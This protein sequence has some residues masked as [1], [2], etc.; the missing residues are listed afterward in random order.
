MVAK[1]RARGAKSSI[2]T[3][4]CSLATQELVVAKLASS[5]LTVED[6]HSLG[7]YGLDGPATAQLF[8]SFDAL[9]SL[10]IPY[11][12]PADTSQP[13]S[14]APQW[15][16]FYRLR[17]LKEG[18][19]FGDKTKKKP[20]RYTQPGAT[21]VCA[22][23]PRLPEFSW[24]E[25]MRNPEVDIY[26]T[27][28][29]LKAAKAVKEGFPTIGLGGVYN[30]AS[31]KL[32]HLF[33]PE[34]EKINW[35]KRQ[36]FIIY[37]SDA[38]TNTMVCR[39]IN[40]L[41]EELRLRGALP[42]NVSLPSLLGV[43]QKTGLDDY[44]ISEGPEGLRSL[45]NSAYHLTFARPLWKLN[46]QFAFIQSTGLVVE[47]ETG[48]R[49][50][51]PKFNEVFSTSTYLSQKINDKGELVQELVPASKAWLTWPL[52][53]TLGIVTY[54]PGKPKIIEHADNY[55]RTGYNT[56]KGWGTEPRKGDVSMF[57][58]LVNHLFTG[59][60]SGAK[61]WF[62][63][64]C[65]YPFQYP[66]IK[67]FT[68]VIL[69]GIHHGTG[70][71]QVGY[72]LRRLYGEN[73]AEIKEGDLHGSFND[74]AANR[75][76]VLAD[77]ITGSAK[78]Q[79]ADLLK[80]LITQKSLRI[81]AKYLPEY[82][83]PDCVNYLFTSNSVDALFLEDHDRRY[84]V[85]EVTVKPLS[86]EFYM[87]F[88]VWLS[89]TEGQAALM[90]YFQKQVNV[91]DFNPAAPALRTASKERMTADSMSD[92]GS[93]VR[94]LRDSP[95]TALRM[96]P[97]HAPLVGDLFTNKQL[98][99]LYD[100]IGQTRT[101]ANGLGRELKRAGFAQVLGGQQVATEHSFDRYYAI[102][103]SERWEHCTADDVKRHLKTPSY[104]PLVRKKG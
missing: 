45:I 19:G 92:L 66:G 2:S 96:G 38:G 64:W 77:D 89:T 24:P 48:E 6:G 78:R 11:W 4:T 23:F 47:L 39:A 9:P 76:F 13:L 90:Y 34:L 59:A 71:S 74:W 44:L 88:D 57:H 25:V 51:V 85:H 21:G 62:L 16:Q 46:D 84:F 12:D 102:R 67:L 35:V 37:D 41:S 98:L 36:V 26:I 27:E 55:R 18:T 104:A 75:Q 101:S 52:R 58:K 42:Y 14:P 31:P 40:A 50:S 20:T 63:K 5:G 100:P 22:Y 103:R 8:F 29:E 69:H 53:H 83:L 49:Y 33:L 15:P 10:M 1:P 97:G 54:S 95:N 93:W 43:D 70:K 91:D 68:A 72:A 94:Q 30:F 3:P 28:G 87:E 7:M 61:E 79:D 86:E 32:G 17:Y 82:T 73:F 99:A 56:W 65:A 60:E 80:K 81:N